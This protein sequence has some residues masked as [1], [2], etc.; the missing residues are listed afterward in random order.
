MQSET[1]RVK[2]DFMDGKE[3]FQPQQMS[4]VRSGEALL[5]IYGFVRYR[6]AFKRKHEVR[7]CYFYDPKKGPNHWTDGKF[8]LHGP[9]AYNSHT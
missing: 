3:E 4:K 1:L 2:I 6:D 9:P 5:A 8:K 7:F